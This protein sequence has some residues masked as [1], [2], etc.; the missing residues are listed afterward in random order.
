MKTILQASWR[1]F[2]RFVLGGLLLAADPWLIAAGRPPQAGN[3]THPVPPAGLEFLRT[4][5]RDVVQA[6]RVKPGERRGNSP[7]NTMGFVLICPGGNYPAY[8]IRDFAMSLESG[9]ITSEEMLNHLRLTARVQNGP[10]MRKLANGLIIPPFAIPD[11]VNFDGSAVFYP[12]TYSSGINQGNGAYGILPPVDD[13]YE[14]VHIAYCLFR[15][16]GSATFLREKI[17]GMILLERL[18]AAFHAPQVDPH[19]ELVETDAAH[20]AVGFGFVDSVNMTGKLLFPSLLRYRAAGQLAEIFQ[21]EGL[22]DKA[23]SYRLIQKK[24]ARNLGPAFSDPSRLKGWLRASTGISAQADVWGT[25]YALQLRVLPAR[26][27]KQAEQTILE[28]L[29][30]GTITYEA[31]VRHVPTNM[32]YSIHSA[33]ERTAGVPI[34][35]Y[36]NGAYWHTPTGWLIAVAARKDHA[37][38]RQ[39]VDQYL[40]H[41]RKGDYRMGEGRQAPWETFGPNGYAQN[42]VYMTSVALPVAVLNSLETQFHSLMPKGERE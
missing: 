13:H 21:I 7:T 29:R 37:L 32:N 25:L 2:W 14:F 11:H 23:Q 34:N 36:Q 6:A 19:T 15:A 39:L 1:W 30:Q 40:E 24:I 41:L 10:A 3:P 4:M 12:G 22:P 26:T 28:A 35:V 38:A 17:D 18:T 20:R 33:W 5:T 8:W 9:F 27:A 42:G 31:A 16:T